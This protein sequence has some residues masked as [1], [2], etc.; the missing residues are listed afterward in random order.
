MVV[1]PCIYVGVVDAKDGAMT[2]F[3]VA[4]VT[5]SVR[6]LKGKRLEL[7]TPNLVHTY[8]MAAAR[9]TGRLKGQRS[10]SH[11]NENRHGGMAVCE[12]CCCCRR[13]IAC[14]LTAYVSIWET[15]NT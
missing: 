10:R 11:G 12:V 8:S 6:A 4:S 14:R 13:G 5:V 15:K 9:H 3:S 7:S 2:A 1:I